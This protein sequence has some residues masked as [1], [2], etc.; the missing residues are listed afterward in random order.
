MIEIA[1]RS[2]F[3][4]FKTD[5]TAWNAAIAQSFEQKGHKIW[6]ANRVTR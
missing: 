5:F 4:D 1:H 3:G 2:R 6:I